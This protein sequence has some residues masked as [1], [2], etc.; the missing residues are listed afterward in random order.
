MKDTKE[1]ENQIAQL[2]K[3]FK[4]FSDV[5]M[6]ATETP[7]MGVEPVENEPMEDTPMDNFVDL[8]YCLKQSNEQSIVFHHQTTS[9]SCHNA[10][11]NYYNKIVGL[12]DGLIE[13]VSGIYGRPMGYELVNPVDYQS[14]EQVQ[15]YFQALYAE[16]QSERQVTFQESWIQNQID[17]ISE[18]IAETL[19]LLT[20]K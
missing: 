19:Y 9:F 12:L 14:V 2:E 10:M 6:S 5:E 3:Q 15:A 11:D 13:S 4:A 1:F 20:L 16:V 7:I 8:V 18:L 17:G